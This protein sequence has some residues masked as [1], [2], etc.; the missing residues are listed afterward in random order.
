MTNRYDT[1]E[2]PMTAAGQGSA[3]NVLAALASIFIPGFGQLL[4]G[5]WILGLFQFVLAAMLWLVW[6]GWVVHL[7]SVINAARYSPPVYYR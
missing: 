4:Q 2:T 7:W 3:G 6:L 1:R 5:R